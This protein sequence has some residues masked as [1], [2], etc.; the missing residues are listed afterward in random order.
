[1]KL[2]LPTLLII[3]CL[4]NYSLTHAGEKVSDI[5]VEGLQRLDPG[6]VFN[7][8]PF[9]INDDI[10]NIDYTK[11]IKLIYK[12]GQFKDVIIERKGSVIIISLSE[13]P[14][15]YEI[16]FYGAETFQPDALLSALNSMGI[17]SG[18]IVDDADLD[19]AKKEITSQYLSYAKYNAVVN[20]EIIPLSNNRVNINFYIDEG[21]IS[22][23]KEINIIGNTQFD[24]QDIL[25]QIS[26][27]TTNYM[28]WW[29]KDDRYSRQVLMGDLEKIK[30]FYMDKGYLDFKIQS[31]QVSIS[32]TKK[33][34][35]IN[36]S[37][38]E[39]KKYNIGKIQISGSIL[40]NFNV[41][42]IKKEIKFSPGDIF[43]RKL[44]NESVKGMSHLLGNYGYAFANV[45]PVPF[46]DKEAR[47][48]DFNFVVEHGNKI[49][50]RRVNIVGNESTKDEVIRRE[51]RQYE[52]SYFS[53]E[54]I[55]LSVLRLNRTEYFEK[56]DIETP[57]VPG[58]SDQVD[59][60]IVVKETNTGKFSIGAGVSSSEGLIG[61][62][63]LSQANFLGTGNLVATDVS[64]G[65]I[66]KVYSFSFTDPYW[67][68]DGVSR[69]FSASLRDLD[70]KELST[71]DYKSKEVGLGMFFGIPLDEFKK[72]TAGGELSLN[73][74]DLQSTS[75][76]KYLN[77]CAEFNGA[78]STSCDADSFRLWAS[79]SDNTIDNP[80]FA[81]SGHKI[82]LTADITTPGLDLEYYKLFLK[83][84][85]YFSL[86]NS[87]VTK[88]RGSMGY[89]D[90]YGD[91]PFP[92]FKNFRAGG[93]SSLRGYKEGSVGKKTYD[94][95]AGGYVTYGGEKI[96]TFGVETFFPVPFIDKSDQYRLSAFVDGGGA[97]EDSING[98][99]MRYSAGISVLW[100]SPFGPL[101]ASIALPLNEGDNEQT[102]KF[103]FGMGSSF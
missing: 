85:K 61:T 100:V 16:K 56:V 62:L 52:A 46:V 3:F 66:N 33:N 95:N 88:I 55:D 72:L 4:L 80:F 60:N 82:Y 44:V 58:T 17:A 24:T 86:S 87:V 18:M 73:E 51:I 5:Q 90:S 94:S 28:S 14:L 31:S 12:T 97:F 29:N 68:D 59:L 2:L 49:Y 20:Y 32:K 11:T 70:T 10:D 83:G 69:G 54:K 79:W 91:E 89:A 75:P 102:E 103:Q 19:K 26:L 6:L 92:F 78:G 21:K 40:D 53:Q 27:K 67:T 13:K 23:I 38:D 101:N 43:N 76:Q 84:E 99:E 9:E 64:F 42:E 71:G 15:A 96:L 93:K 8:L 36:I 65:G 74:L 45:N 37:I 35:Y 22:K 98:S 41:D 48:V 63:G 47:K 50:V 39:G 57:V 34:V 1:M 7:S 81:T 77:Y 25:K 30:S